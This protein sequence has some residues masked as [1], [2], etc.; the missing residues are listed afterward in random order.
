MYCSLIML[1]CRSA[2]AG[3]HYCI[4][5]SRLDTWAASCVQPGATQAIVKC[6]CPASTC[7]AFTFLLYILLPPG[8][9]C[10]RL[11][12]AAQSGAFLVLYAKESGPLAAG[13][14]VRLVLGRY[15]CRST[16]PYKV[17]LHSTIGGY[18]WLVQLTGPATQAR[19][20]A[21]W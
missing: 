12:R 2:G 13:I 15:V 7:T 14:P 6:S 17:R 4:F 16:V 18:R 3:V 9:S 10:H 20:T 19:T 21:R 8:P 1:T 5:G 11:F